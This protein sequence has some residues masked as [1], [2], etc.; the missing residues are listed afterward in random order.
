MDESNDFREIFLIIIAC[1]L[2]EAG[3]HFVDNYRSWEIIF[4]RDDFQN[5]KYD[6]AEI[7]VLCCSGVVWLW[8]MFLGF[9]KER[10]HK[11]DCI[12]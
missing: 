9:K 5:A 2:K 12:I 8:G 4:I 10:A 3:E 7:E 11:G 1:L 6:G